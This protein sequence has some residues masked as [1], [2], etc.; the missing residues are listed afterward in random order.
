VLNIIQ[1]GEYM[2]VNLYPQAALMTNQGNA[3]SFQ[4]PIL[5]SFPRLPC[6]KNVFMEKAATLT[7]KYSL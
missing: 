7:N 2:T 4:P 3:V 5:I 6:Y 1:L